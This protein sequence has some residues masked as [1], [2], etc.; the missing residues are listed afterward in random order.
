MQ[1]SQVKATGLKVFRLEACSAEAIID[2]VVAAFTQE[3]AVSLAKPTLE[4]AGVHPSA[5]KVQEVPLSG[6]SVLLAV[7]QDFYED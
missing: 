1:S 2:V 5:A 4:A 6:P 7:C 3:E